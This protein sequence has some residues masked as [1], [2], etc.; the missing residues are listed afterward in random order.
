MLLSC[1]CHAMSN[2]QVKNVPEAV[3]DE[4]R[5]RADARG[6]TLRDFV[7]ELLRREVARP[8]FHDWL[9]RVEQRPPVTSAES[10]VEALDDER[11]QHEAHRGRV[12]DRR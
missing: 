5:R 1:Y 7:L 11:A 2:L 3:H 10:V 12:L 6:I 4:L 8:D 9:A